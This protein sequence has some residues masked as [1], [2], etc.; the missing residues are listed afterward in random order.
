[1]PSIEWPALIGNSFLSCW[2][3]YCGCGWNRPESGPP[4]RNVTKQ[5]SSAEWRILPSCSARSSMSCLLLSAP[6]TPSR[7][8]RYRRISTNRNSSVSLCN[9]HLFLFNIQSELFIRID[10]Y[11]GTRPA[12]SGWHFYLF[13][14]VLPTLTRFVVYLNEC[15]HCNMFVNWLIVFLFILLPGFL[16]SIDTNN[17]HVSNDQSERYC[18]PRLSL[19]AQSLHHCVPSG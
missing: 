6:S 18:S 5:S 14:S 12:S 16:S 11:I 3:R 15:R 2:E 13:I 19:H 17:D 7:Q 9:Y 4:I 8:E 10:D 1:M